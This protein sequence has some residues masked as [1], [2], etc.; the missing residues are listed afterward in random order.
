MKR[1]LVIKPSSLG[2]I[3]HGLLVAESIRAQCP[4]VEIHWV[5]REIFAP[6]VEACETVSKVHLFHRGAGLGAFGQL[7]QDVREIEYDYVLDMQGL[8]RSGVIAGFSKTPRNRRIGRADDREGASISCGKRAILP[9]DFPEA[10]AVDILRGFLSVL[11][12]ENELRGQLTFTPPER[13]MPDLPADYVL[14]FPGSRRAEK[15]WWGFSDLTK[16]ILNERPE[17]P[18]V[19]TGDV[20]APT[21]MGCESIRNLTGQTPL[22]VLPQMIAHARL[23]VCNDSGP[24][25]LAAALKRPVVGIFGPTSPR[26]FGPYPLVAPQNRVVEAP[27]G[28]LMQLDV[29]SVWQ[30]LDLQ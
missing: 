14:I 4:G 17:I 21:P 30:E 24:M 3:I 25:H 5:A 9:D 28:K 27:E 20:E 12:L 13:G 8:A 26:R 19:W 10:H 15:E 11:E 1:I 7:I 16:R 2:D 22:N 23:V 18:V 29:Q 6:L